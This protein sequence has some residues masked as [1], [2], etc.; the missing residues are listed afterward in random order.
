[1]TA[2]DGR[3]QKLPIFDVHAAC[4]VQLGGTARTRVLAADAGVHP[5]ERGGPDVSHPPAKGGAAVDQQGDA[6]TLGDKGGLIRIVGRFV[7]VQ[8]R[9]EGREDASR[10]RRAGPATPTTMHCVSAEA[11]EDIAVQNKNRVVLRLQAHNPCER[12]RG[13]PRSPARDGSPHLPPETPEGLGVNDG[14]TGGP[15]NDRD[16]KA[17]GMCLSISLVARGDPDPAEAADGLGNI[18]VIKVRSPL[19][20]VVEDA[21]D[22]RDAP[23]LRH[24]R[25]EGRARGGTD[26]RGR[27]QLELL[28]I[29]DEAKGRVELA[30]DLEGVADEVRT[31][32]GIR[33][34]GVIVRTVGRRG[35]PARAVVGI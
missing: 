30:A 24:L 35:H 34:R 8:H 21:Q 7:S 9:R 29:G 15:S 25:R 3:P 19:V 2:D 23:C 22:F 12:I 4:E 17:A 11:E 16:D 1:M 18:A 28:D 5:N 20:E 10:L 13:G 6:A 31:F 26:P 14:E 33:L 27:G 32:L